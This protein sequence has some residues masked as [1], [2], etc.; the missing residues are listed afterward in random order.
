MT[1]KA[2]SLHRWRVAL[3]TGT[4]AK[5]LGYVEARDE[6]AAIEVA[7]RKYRIGDTLRHKIVARREE[8]RPRSRDH[9]G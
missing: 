6:R 2:K 1:K 9:S 7:V 5:F 8:Y 4:P 3:M